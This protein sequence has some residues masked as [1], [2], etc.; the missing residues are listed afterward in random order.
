[1][2]KK[3]GVVSALALVVA[4]GGCTADGGDDPINRRPK[5]DSSPE[6]PALP[7]D[8]AEANEDPERRCTGKGEALVDGRLRRVRIEVT[9]CPVPAGEAPEATLTNTGETAVG[10]GPPFKLE[11]KA[12]NGWRWINR[13]QG[14]I[15]PLFHLEPGATGEPQP[16][17]VYFKSPKPVE[18]KPGVYRVTKSV[19]LTL[20]EAR[21]PEMKVSTQFRVIG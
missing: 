19:Q 6:G 13:R 17:A 18:L 1:M 16:L 15:L 5:A 3:L 9:P 11:K 20:D 14:F 12:S 2:S 4:L 7:S 21:P 8:D 10:Y